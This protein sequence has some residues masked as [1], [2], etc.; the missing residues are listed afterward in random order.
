MDVPR[1]VFAGSLNLFCCLAHVC[2]GLVEYH[3]RISFIV[4]HLNDEAPSLVLQRGWTFNRCGNFSFLTSRDVALHSSVSDRA[5]RNGV[6]KGPVGV[7]IP[8]PRHVPVAPIRRNFPLAPSG[9]SFLEASPSRAR[10]EGRIAIVTDVGR[11]M[12]WTL[13]AAQDER[14]L[15]RAAKSRGPDP[16]TLGSRLRMTNPQTTVTTSPVHRGERV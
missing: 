1:D 11:G 16:P 13:W 7:H 10:D 8:V 2:R 9:K 6:R 12:R 5:M 4:G 15:K 3:R 14:S